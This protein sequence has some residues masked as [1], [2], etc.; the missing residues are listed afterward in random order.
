[1]RVTLLVIAFT[2][3][4]FALASADQA[5]IDTP[6]HRRGQTW[7]TWTEVSGPSVTYDVYKSTTQITSLSG[8]SPINPP[9]SLDQDSG[10]LKYVDD[11]DDLDTGFVITDNGSHLASNKGLAVSTTATTGCY[12]YAVVNSGDQSVTV[13]VNSLSSCV[14]ETRQDVTGAVL[15]SKTIN[16]EGSGQTVWKYFAWDDITQWH[17]GSQGYYGVRFSV[18]GP[19]TLTTGPLDV[20]LHASG[21][22]GYSSLVASLTR[23]ANET[24]VHLMTADFNFSGLTDPYCNCAYGEGHHWGRYDS[25][26]GFFHPYLEDRIVRFAKMVR[27][28]LTGDGQ[29][30]KIDGNRV[31]V[32]GASLGSASG[33]VLSR[34]GDVF[35]AGLM[36]IGYVDDPAHPNFDPTDSIPLYGGGGITVFDSEDLAQNAAVRELRPLMHYFGGDDGTVTPQH[37]DEAMSAFETYHQ[38]YA[39][40]WEPVGHN[41]DDI[42]TDYPHWTFKR[43]KKNEAYP[44]FSGAANSTTL[45]SFPVGTPGQ[46]NAFLD[47]DSALHDIGGGTAGNMLDKSYRFEVALKSTSGSD[48]TATTTMRNFQEFLPPVGT[49]VQW[50]NFNNYDGSGSLIASGQVTVASDHSITI[51]S[52]AIKSAGNRL[53]INEEVGEAG[54]NAWG[55]YTSLPVCTDYGTS[56]TALGASW[57]LG[58]PATTASP[59]ASDNFKVYADGVWVG[60]RGMVYVKNN[61]NLYEMSTNGRWYQ[62]T[63]TTGSYSF[64]VQGRGPESVGC[65]LPTSPNGSTVLQNNDYL[66]DSVGG[67]WIATSREDAMEAN[68]YSAYCPDFVCGGTID[69]AVVIRNGNRFPLNGGARTMLEPNNVPW[70]LKWCGGEMYKHD[71]Y[72]AGT[73]HT[74]SKWG[75]IGVEAWTDATASACAAGPT[76]AYKRRNRRTLIR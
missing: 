44:A 33:H 58:W 22:T 39:A 21:N 31:Y 60:A 47:W 55:D 66:V 71:Y 64:T 74:Y 50:L 75:G 14:S 61:G 10:R 63:G 2:L 8:L 19:D 28:N 67:V 54:N 25:G 4:I 29:D 43:F 23:N 56:V 3:G 62:I 20:I 1:M 65:R 70:N 32:L 18:A 34:H 57:T 6:A 52:L 26:T 17:P 68:D 73:P 30:F 69:E 7:I 36:M 24:N 72:V 51:P 15:L 48:T 41:Q 59:A 35:A 11:V 42:A 9:S 27:D 13:G 49:Q 12:Y 53:V 38:P 76:N 16:A 46:R 5:A 45:P 37:Y 40:E